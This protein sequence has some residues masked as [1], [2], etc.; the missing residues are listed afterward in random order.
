MIQDILNKSLL[1]AVL[2]EM[3]ERFSLIEGKQS[4]DSYPPDSPD[5]IFQYKKD[6]TDGDLASQQFSFMQQ[7]LFYERIFFNIERVDSIYTAL[8]HEEKIHVQYQLNYTDSLGNTVELSGINIDKGFNTNSIPVV[9]GTRIGAIVKISPPVI[10]QNMF[11]VLIVSVLIFFFIIACL[12]YQVNIFLTQ[13]Q[14]HQLR[15]NFIHTLNHNMKTPLATIHSVLAQLN[16]GSLASQPEIK[17]KFTQIAIEQTVNLQEIIDQLLT[18]VYADRKPL[19]INKQKIDLPQMI[20]SLVDEFMI[21]KEKE[22]VFSEKY[23]L[24]DNPVYADPFY[25]KN[26]ISNLIDNAIKYSGDTVKIDIKCLME[27]KRISIGIK[28]NGFGISEKDQQKIYD[29]FERGA[30]IKRKRISGFG[31]GLNYVK[32]VI[33]AHNGKVALISREGIGSEFTISIPAN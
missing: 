22:I 24:K 13:N 3:D 28:D 19:T 10:L 4:T 30:E 31:L 14:L 20:L 5:V 16:N 15:E 6:E 27:D 17:S 2:G 25:L 18:V 21:R 9:N 11:E 12:I 32:Y 7:I 29:P 26:A 8:L 1:N 23:H 33:E